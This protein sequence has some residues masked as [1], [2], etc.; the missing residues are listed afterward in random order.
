MS[1]RLHVYKAL[2]VECRAKFSFFTK[3][4]ASTMGIF[5]FLVAIR[6]DVVLIFMPQ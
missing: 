5:V 6:P 2:G 1:Q 4:L 3:F